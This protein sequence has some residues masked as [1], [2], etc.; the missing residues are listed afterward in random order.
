MLVIDGTIEGAAIPKKE[1]EKAK[2][3]PAEVV[4]VQLYVWCAIF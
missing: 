4:W 1:N 2:W 3:A